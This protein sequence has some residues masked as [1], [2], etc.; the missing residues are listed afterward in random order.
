MV[1][2]AQYSTSPYI[3]QVKRSKADQLSRWKYDI[4]DYTLQQKVFHQILNCFCNSIT[5]AVDM[6]VS[7]GNAKFHKFVSRWPHYQAIGTD[8]L[9]KD[10][11]CIDQCYAN[12]PWTLILQWLEKLRRHPHVRCLTIVPYWVGNAWWPLLLRLLD[13]HRPVLLF[14]PQ[15]G[16]FINCL[17]QEMPPT[18]L[19]LICVVLSGKHYRENKFHLKIS[20]IM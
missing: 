5:P 2:A 1:H 18:R 15:Q 6:F 8:A 12:P 16:L 17:G 7:P 4:G 13:R 14:R 9:K 20:K 3:S 11:T 19:P 10:L